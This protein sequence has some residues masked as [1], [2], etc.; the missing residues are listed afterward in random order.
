MIQIRQLRC[1]HPA[2]AFVQVPAFQ[3]DAGELLKEM[4][5]NGERATKDRNVNQHARVSR[6]TTPS[7][8]SDIG[9]S[10][11]QSSSWQ[12]HA[13]ADPLPDGYRRTAL[14]HRQQC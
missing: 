12:K 6:D 11:D 4:A 7:T 8:L 5:G 13:A 9:I 3:L 1:G 2:L 10:R 14:R